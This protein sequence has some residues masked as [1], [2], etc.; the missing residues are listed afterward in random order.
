MASDNV[1]NSIRKIIPFFFPPLF[2][3]NFSLFLFNIFFSIF[4]VSISWRASAP[5]DEGKNNTV[6]K[7]P[8][9]VS[10]LNKFSRIRPQRFSTS[11]EIT[12]NNH[13][14]WSLKYNSNVLSDN[15]F[16]F[17]QHIYLQHKFIVIFLILSRLGNTNVFVSLSNS[18]SN[19]TLFFSK[20]LF[21]SS[22]IFPWSR[23]EDKVSK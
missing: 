2:F 17:I 3:F 19:E 20:F 8:P 5:I 16:A 23:G 7:I 6:K 9:P 11:P 13:S 1:D 15:L 12:I 14:C 21:T 10:S 4:V 22:T 18:Q